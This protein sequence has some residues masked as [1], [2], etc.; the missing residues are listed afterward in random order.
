[1]VYSVIPKPQI[2]QRSSKYCTRIREFDVFVNVAVSLMCILAFC[3]SFI[4][5]E[6]RGCPFGPPLLPR[7]CPASTPHFSEG[8]GTTA[9]LNDPPI[10]LPKVRCFAAQKPPAH[11]RVSHVTWKIMDNPRL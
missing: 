10:A 4:V 3:G 11:P 6:L 5:V 1:M 7:L 8:A 2:G 9:A